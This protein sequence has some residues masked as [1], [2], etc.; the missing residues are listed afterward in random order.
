ME[1][2]R[3]KLQQLPHVVGTLTFDENN[4]VVTVTGIASDR[5]LDI[6][7]ISKVE[8]DSEGFGLVQ[9]NNLICNIYR[10]DN[11]TVVIYQD[12]NN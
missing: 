5:I 11:N 12:K 10:Q 4:N 3:N 8:L 7:S 9:I 2:S 6:D 1:T